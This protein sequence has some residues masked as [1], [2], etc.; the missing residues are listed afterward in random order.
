MRSLGN[1]Q[2][3]RSM[4]RVHVSADNAAKESLPS[5]LQKKVRNSRRRQTRDQLRLAI[6]TW[7]ERAYRRRRR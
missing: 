4:S 7:I 6:V 2:L 3:K 1:H 5:L